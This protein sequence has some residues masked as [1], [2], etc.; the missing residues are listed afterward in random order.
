MSVFLTKIET[1]GP[2]LLES[3]SAGLHGVLTLL[4]ISSNR[5]EDC[6]AA[7]CLLTMLKA[8]IDDVLQGDCAVC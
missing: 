6:H 1:D 4:E 3:V 7:H 2:T 5:S 8:R